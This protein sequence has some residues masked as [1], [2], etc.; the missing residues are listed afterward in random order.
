M[1][2]DVHYTSET[3]AEGTGN[4]ELRPEEESV[5]LGRKKQNKNKR[6]KGRMR[7]GKTVSKQDGEEISEI[8]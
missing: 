4:T 6:L 1:R 2:H 5:V 7:E 8:L 3:L